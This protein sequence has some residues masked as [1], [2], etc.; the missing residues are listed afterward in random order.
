MARIYVSSTFKDLKE[1]R[2]QVIHLLRRM[3]HE[4]VA[5]ED[6]TA[7]EQW[8]A[9]KC[10]AD[11][12]ACDL[13]VGIFAWR[14]G[15]IP[16]DNN[17][18]N[19]S[20]SELEYR[21]AGEAGRHRLIFIL[22]E[23]ASWPRPMMDRDPDRIEDFRKRFSATHTCSIFTTPQEI[24]GLLGPAINNWAREHGHIKSGMSIPAFD[25]DA[26]FVALSKRYQRLELEGLTQPR[27]EEYL[28]LQLSNIF[29]EQSVREDHPPVELTKEAWDRLRVEREVHDD[30]LPT[31][32]FG[33]A[34]SDLRRAREVYFEKPRLPVL[35]VITDPRYRR[36]V[37]LGDPGSGKSTLSRYVSIA[38]AIR[39][40]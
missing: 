11:V 36:M 15:F 16:S 14:Y 4:V 21:K 23:N 31:R 40:S 10:L 38:F 29:V 24:A 35:G 12:A 28:Q 25:L 30:D 19:L 3:R 22:D 27:R 32:E 37:V 8:P 39:P 6:Y 18:D 7:E 17:P 13:Y 34:S 9:D 20:I 1:C 33:L 2:D 5:M 26:Y